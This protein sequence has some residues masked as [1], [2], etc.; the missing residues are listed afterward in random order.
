MQGIFLG[1]SPFSRPPIK[2]TLALDSK[3]KQSNPEA[4]CK[5]W[6]LES[7]SKTHLKGLA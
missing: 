4:L 7:K 3:N 2:T 6:F 1:F 5:A